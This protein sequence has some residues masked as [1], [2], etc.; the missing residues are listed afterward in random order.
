MMHRYPAL[1]VLVLCATTTFAQYRQKMDFQLQHFLSQD[2]GEKEVGLF[3]H[4]DP[5]AVGAAVYLH[6]GRITHTS[7]TFV[8]ARV[9]V[10][11]VRALANEGAVHHFEF[12][13]SRGEL[14]ND[15]M[16]V[17]SRANLVQMGV[18]PLPQGFDGTGV[19]FGIIDTGLDITHPD[20]RDEND[21]TRVYRYWDQ[22]PDGSANSPM[23]YGYGT[24]F[25]REQLNAGGP[26]LPADP[27]GHGT[28]VAGSAVG[29][30]LA[31]GRHKGVAPKAEIVVVASRLGSPNWAASVADGVR[32]IFEQADA[33]GMPAV[34]NIS[35]GSYTGS[36]DGK[37]A[38]GLL[39]EEMLLEQSGR[40]VTAAGGNSHG[41]FPYHVHTE[42]D[43]DTSFTW[44]QT[45]EFPPQ[46]NV[47]DFPNVF[48]EVW[49]DASAIQ[50]VRFAIGADRTIPN[51]NFRG[52]TPFHTVADA[53]G[54]VVSEPLI[55][56]S[57]HTLG[58]A[59]FYAQQRGDQVML[60]VMI[61]S[62]DTADCLWRFMSTGSGSFDL[63]SLVTYTRTANVIGPELAAAWPTPIPFPSP[64]EYPAMAHYVA[65]DFLQHIV[66]SWACVPE[67][68]TAANYC[69]EV[70]YTDYFGVFR[71]VAGVEEDLAVTSSYGP[72]RDGRVKPDLAATGDLTFTAG[73]LE[74]IQ[75]I[76]DNQVGWKVDP[77]GMHIRDGGT[78]QAAPV[79][80]G[81]ALLYLQHCPGAA[82]TE[83][84][85]AIRKS[86]RR[87]QF[88]G[89]VPNPRWGFGKLDVYAAVLNK[90]GLRAPTTS[91]CEGGSLVVEYVGWPAQLQ[92]SNGA[93]GNVIQVST[94]GPISA[95]A[96]SPSGCIAY[97][98]TLQLVIS[99]L[100]AEPTIS[101]NASVLTSSPALNYQ[102]LEGGQPIE[103]ATTQEWT[104]YW[105]GSYQVMVTDANGCSSVSQP[106]PVL[107][108]GVQENSQRG[109]AVWPSPVRDVLYIVVPPTT[110]GAI[111]LRVFAA[112]GKLVE[113]QR[114]A[115]SGSTM[116]LDVQD[117][118]PGTYTI[119]IGSSEGMENHRFVKTQ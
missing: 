3:I 24:Q 60:Q 63:W 81:A 41:T 70:S 20:F 105:P 91:I 67:V 101:A 8:A 108:V 38:A 85:S 89:P 113:Q 14:M 97:T 31:N 1:A 109:T 93:S 22:V 71:E 86:L 19:L 54:Q 9:P 44:F 13:L 90:T 112:D 21:Q 64:A 39:I 65:P 42:V 52:H 102:W 95:T 103:G 92:W 56:S 94:P 87:D 33:L 35:M 88:T 78:S 18:S 58:T 7:K 76:I 73:P 66:D 4:G 61:A 82:V 15:S 99:P 119:S 17:K 49:A 114:T 23:P 50:N 27:Q 69:N 110:T 11:N 37:D 72:T 5:D 100:P 32:Y 68:L 10:A 116:E 51:L 106:V 2:N 12:S 55:S 25:T 118:A 47:F 62:P 34:V 79:V 48:F 111:H 53:M 30:G 117:L 84:T 43:Q 28:A 40:I 45:N 59:Q 98:D 74:A 75:W 96:V 29:N 36:H 6:G 16:R 115:Y 77:G 80:A 104:A 107:T 57:G 83:V 46:Y 26:G